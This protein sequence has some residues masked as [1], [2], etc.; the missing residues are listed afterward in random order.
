MGKRGFG[1]QKSELYLYLPL[2]GMWQCGDE[3]RVYHRESWK[4]NRIRW[5]RSNYVKAA[6]CTQH[7]NLQIYLLLRISQASALPWGSGFH[8]A[9]KMGG[10]VAK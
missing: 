6:R 8:S 4:L 2:H 7:S 5:Q 10:A 3:G 9:H 1:R